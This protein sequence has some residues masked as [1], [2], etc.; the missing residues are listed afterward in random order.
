MLESSKAPVKH[1]G[2]MPASQPQAQVNQLRHQR[3]KFAYA[4]EGQKEEICTPD[5][6]MPSSFMPE[7]ATK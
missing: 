1:M 6:S 7:T 3:I 4:N 2:N 5:R